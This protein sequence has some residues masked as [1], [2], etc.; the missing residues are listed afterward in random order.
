MPKQFS[1]DLKRGTVTLL[2][3]SRSAYYFAILFF[4][5]QWSDAADHAALEPVKKLFIAMSARDG[6]AMRSTGTE[7]FQLLEQGEVW[8]MDKLVSVVKAPRK[9]SE[10]KNF[11]QQ[12]AARQSG[13]MAWVSYWNKAE[14]TR[15]GELR[16]IVW[17]E[18]A[19]MIKVQGQW[20]I[21]LLH[22]TRVEADK[23]PKDIE[24]NLIE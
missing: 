20:T 11:F 9:T 12:I 13:D 7:N 3:L 17:L 6:D 22:S 5:T 23:Q 24:W 1:L 15:E 8:S 16:K 2:C 14:I 21:Q 10:R 19:V 18:S 4:C